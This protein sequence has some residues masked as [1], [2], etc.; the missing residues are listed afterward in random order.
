MIAATFTWY[1]VADGKRA[2][3]RLSME[4][5]ER[6]CCACICMIKSATDYEIGTVGFFSVHSLRQGFREPKKNGMCLPDD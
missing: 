5:G 4:R 6:C 1:V 2:K 3:K